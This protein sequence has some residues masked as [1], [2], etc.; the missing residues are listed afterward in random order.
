MGIFD[1]FTE[2]AQKVL[3]F[4]QEEAVRLRHNYIGTEHILL[5]LL[6]EGEGL[7]A[8][9]LKSRG[10]NIED[11]RK[12][13]VSAVGMG[14]VTVSQVIGYTPRT[15]N[16]IEISVNEARMLGH[17]YVGTEHLLLALVREGEGIAAQNIAEF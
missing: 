17:N 3:V 10:V 8:Q 4:A 16:V 15:K 13:V 2:K 14:D 6:R 12:R 5:G 7:A 9:A 11:V 1:R